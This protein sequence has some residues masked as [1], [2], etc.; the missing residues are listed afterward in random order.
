[1]TRTLSST[2]TALMV[3][4]SLGCH[5]PEPAVFNDGLGVSEDRTLIVP[6]REPANSRW[7]GE[8]ENGIVVAEALKEWARGEW[9]ADFPEGDEAEEALTRI[10]DW[11]KTE[12]TLR[13]WRKLTRGLGVRYVVVGEFDKLHVRSPKMVAMID[14]RAKVTYRVIDVEKGRTALK[15]TKEIE[16]GTNHQRETPILDLGQDL[17]VVRRRLLAKVGR[18]LG[19]DLYGYLDH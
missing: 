13:D 8:S 6:L 16:Y 17:R 2:V 1:M 11:D 3:L 12:I 4:G 10:R 14:A 18:E 5:G 9:G 7:Y 19:K 15:R